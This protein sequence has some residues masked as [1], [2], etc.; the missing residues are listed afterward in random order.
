MKEATI[1]K[2]MD[3][4]I[5]PRL[6]DFLDVDVDIEQLKIEGEEDFY[7]LLTLTY[8]VND[9][10]KM[11]KYNI[12][13][14]NLPSYKELISKTIKN[15][16]GFNNFHIQYYNVEIPQEKD[17]LKNTF[18][19]E[20]NRKIREKDVMN[21]IHT[22]TYRRDEER[23]DPKIFIS[24]K[25]ECQESDYSNNRLQYLLKDIRRL[26]NKEMGFENL[27]IGIPVAW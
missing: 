1:N 24:I 6:P 27:Y 10:E 11:L 8:V 16:G 17:W 19:K 12:E 7:Y 15:Y 22:I 23:I 14:I 4:L 5:K 13:T 18:K 3:L 9:I 25:K 2:I 21:C 26:I 20:I